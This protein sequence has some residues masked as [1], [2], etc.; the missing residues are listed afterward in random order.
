[1]PRIIAVRVEPPE[2]EGMVKKL[3]AVYAA[4]A[5][6]LAH[7]VGDH[8][9]GRED[10]EAVRDAQ[11]GLGETADALD[12]VGWALGARLEPAELAG[13]P[14]LVREVLYAALLDA[15]EGTGEACVAYE[16]AETGLE[17]IRAAVARLT[18]RLELFAA[19]EEGERR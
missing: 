1:M 17:G 6:A 4:K 12:T 7:A 2:V 3:L 5:E 19:H 10:L 13:P 11:R 14:G 16:A 18:A 15:A 9:D 8:L